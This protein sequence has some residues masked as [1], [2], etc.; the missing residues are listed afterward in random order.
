MAV[1]AADTYSA[2]HRQ[3]ADH[4]RTRRALVVGEPLMARP[5][6]REGLRITSSTGAFL[7]NPEAIDLSQPSTTTR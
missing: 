5:A 2:G 7:D 1:V 3:G 6:P 4:D